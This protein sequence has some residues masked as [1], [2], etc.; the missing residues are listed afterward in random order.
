MTGLV[1]T[2]EPIDAPEGDEGE[3]PFTLDGQDYTAVRPADIYFERIIAAMASAATASDKVH[4]VLAF[5]DAAVSPPDRM[6][7]EARFADPRDP[8]RSATQ[9]IPTA[10][11]L[12][13]HWGAD[14][15]DW[16]APDELLKGK[17]PAAAK[18]TTAKAARSAPRARR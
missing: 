17:K 5:L 9:L 6:R 18:T 10:F 1:F 2:T 8:L 4:A 7:I 3:V 12:C 11:A 13:E 16:T 14:T 15:G